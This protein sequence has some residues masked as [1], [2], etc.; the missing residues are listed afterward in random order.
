MIS[1]LQK[2]FFSFFSFFFFPERVQGQTAVVKK[3]TEL[4]TSRVPSLCGSEGIGKLTLLFC[5]VL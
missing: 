2:V 4:L 5:G 1:G 3:L